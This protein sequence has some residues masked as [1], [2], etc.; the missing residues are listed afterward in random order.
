[1]CHSFPSLW[2]QFV[3]LWGRGG[4]KVLIILTALKHIYIPFF[5]SFLS[6]Y[7]TKLEVLEPNLLFPGGI[8]LNTISHP[9]NVIRGIGRPFLTASAVNVFLLFCLS[10]IRCAPLQNPHYGM[11][12]CDSGNLYGSTC[13]IS[14]I[15][16]YSI[17][18]HDRITCKQDGHWS[19]DIPFCRSKSFI[20]L[21]KVEVY[22]PT[23]HFIRTVFSSVSIINTTAVSHWRI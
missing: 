3:L 19:D 4:V 15:P 1:M 7:Y 5:A 17:V 9:K 13:T 16:G 6:F 18:G 8:L 22:N 21:R 2:S 23:C 14:C 10:V 20:S 12:E 11:V